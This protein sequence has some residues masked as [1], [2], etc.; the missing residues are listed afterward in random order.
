MTALAVPL[1]R[2][3]PSHRKPGPLRRLKQRWL[4]HNDD[5]LRGMARELE[6]RAQVKRN[7]GRAARTAAKV[8]PVIAV[9]GHPPYLPAIIAAAIVLCVAAPLGVKW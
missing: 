9:A 5:L 7:A 3:A 1:A 4:D 2:R 8:S 6:E